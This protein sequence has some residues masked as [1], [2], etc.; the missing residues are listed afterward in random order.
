MISLLSWA[1]AS[2]SLPNNVPPGSLQPRSPVPIL[3]TSAAPQGP[4]PGPCWGPTVVSLE[5]ILWIPY[6][7]PSGVG[8]LMPDPVQAAFTQMGMKLAYSELAAVTG[9]SYEHQMLGDYIVL[10]HGTQILH[11]DEC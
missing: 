7:P 2:G 6:Q 11:L 4:A 5:N 8:A 3:S 1:L 10:L 9:V